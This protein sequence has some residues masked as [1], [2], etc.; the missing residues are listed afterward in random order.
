MTDKNVD[1]GKGRLKEAAGSLT[2]DER[3]KNEGKADQAKAS[4][5]DSVDKVADGA[6]RLLDDDK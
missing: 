5:K 1:E 3:L 2:G 4:V 6:K